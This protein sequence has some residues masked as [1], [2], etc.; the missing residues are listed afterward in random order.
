MK[1]KRKNMAKR[2]T[3]KTNND[4]SY[5]KNF[6]IPCVIFLVGYFFSAHNGICYS[7][8]TFVV[9][10]LFIVVFV[11]GIKCLIKS[12]INSYAIG[13]WTFCVSLA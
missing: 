3:A 1:R 9:V 6:V 12:K 13:W 8:F 7:D 10:I 11:V 4:E 2:E 5:Y